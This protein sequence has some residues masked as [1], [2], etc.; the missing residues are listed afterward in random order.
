VLPVKLARYRNPDIDF[1]MKKDIVTR[2]VTL[3][4]LEEGNEA[5]KEFL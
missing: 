4:G 3:N 2:E 1:K 5:R